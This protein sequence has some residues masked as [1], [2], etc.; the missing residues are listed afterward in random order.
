V[1]FPVSLFSFSCRLFPRFPETYAHPK[2]KKMEKTKLKE[3]IPTFFI[4]FAASPRFTPREPNETA[5]WAGA[6]HESLWPRNRVQKWGRSSPTQDFARVQ[7]DRRAMRNL[8]FLGHLLDR[9]G[10]R[11]GDAY[12]D[13]CLSCTL[14][15]PALQVAIEAL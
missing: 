3:V 10:D 11:E 8:L 14:H 15:L 2:L 4:C 7:I 1:F 9:Q 5:C 13:L 6:T 12:G